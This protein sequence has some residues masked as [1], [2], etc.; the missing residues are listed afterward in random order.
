MYFSPSN[1]G[2]IID[3]NNFLVLNNNGLTRLY[4]IIYKILIYVFDAIKIY[5]FRKHTMHNWL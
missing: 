4:E 5:V 3:K 2:I 1:R